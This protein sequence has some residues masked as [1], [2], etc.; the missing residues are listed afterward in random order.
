M[1][2]KLQERCSR[3]IENEMA[4]RQMS[5]LDSEE[6]IKLGA[7]L[8]TALGITEDD[9]K[10]SK[11]RH[12]LQNKDAFFSNLRGV[13][14]SLL[15][16]KMTLSEDPEEYIDNV[17]ATHD[18][19]TEDT[20]VSGL[21]SVLTAVIIYE[22][23][24]DQEIDAV[25][26]TVLEMFAEVKRINPQ[27]SHDSDMAYIALMLL[28]GKADTKVEEEKAQIFDALKAKFQMPSDAA[29]ATTLV[30]ITSNKPAEEK[31]ASFT[32]LYEALKAAGHATSVKRAISIYGAFT[33]IEAPTEEIVE[34]ISDADTFLKSRKGY[35][36]FS[37]SS[38]LRRVV[39]S[40][41]V[42]QYYTIDV[43][44]EAAPGEF[45]VST[46]ISIEALLFIVLMS[47]VVIG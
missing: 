40:T 43:P 19:L 17:I 15:L 36:M 29:H 6:S 32:A 35:G 30:L 5:S 28:S 33:D 37:V 9:E 38:D 26:K 3:Q 24:G 4:F 27:L 12:I 18:K 25:I 23:H 10:M 47:I 45:T 41:L 7:L 8:Y 46:G 39:A 44:S 21:F 34:L 1:N 31:I 16:L 11:C 2:T 42:L 20:V 13:L 22:Q 14:Q